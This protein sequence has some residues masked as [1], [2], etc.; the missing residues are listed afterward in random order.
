MSKNRIVK[1]AVPC[2]LYKTFD[3]RL[4]TQHGNR[5]IQ[6]GVRVRIPFGRQ[7]LVGIIVEEI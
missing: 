2:P 1:V 6:A 5:A 4:N 7:K 3:Y